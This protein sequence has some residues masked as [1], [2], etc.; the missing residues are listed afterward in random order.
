M[1]VHSYFESVF[2]EHFYS[3]R[4]T[5]HDVDKIDILV[6][7]LFF[8]CLCVCFDGDLIVMVFLCS[9]G[10]KLLGFLPFLLSHLL[11]TNYFKKNDNNVLPRISLW[12]FL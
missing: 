10:F 4:L 5:L 9:S 8:V 11:P 2:S 1:I 7:L 12:D 3:Y 6:L